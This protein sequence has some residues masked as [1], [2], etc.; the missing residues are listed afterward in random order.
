MKKLS[1]KQVRIIYCVMYAIGVG[2]ILLGA[3]LKIIWL[4]L[5]ALLEMVGAIIFMIAFYRCP[6][7]GRPLARVG[8]GSFCP[9]CGR[10]IDPSA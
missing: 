10:P 5:V 8:G 4:I 7:C 1:L 3:W 2:L 6:Y 9:Y